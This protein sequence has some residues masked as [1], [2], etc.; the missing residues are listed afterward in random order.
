LS[1]STYLLS[2]CPNCGINAQRGT[3]MQTQGFAKPLTGDKFLGLLKD[4]NH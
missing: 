4:L 1:Q 3:L 2:H